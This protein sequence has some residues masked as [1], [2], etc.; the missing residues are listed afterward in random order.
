MAANSAKDRVFQQFSVL[1]TKRSAKGVACEI[2]KRSEAET[3]QCYM[4]QQAERVDV[5]ACKTLSSGLRASTF[6]LAPKCNLIASKF[7]KFS[8][9][10]C[11]QIPLAVACLR[12]YH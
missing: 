9:G 5:H 1:P 8:G 11:P 7:Q 12:K 3:M 6:V 10:A 4:A 2:S